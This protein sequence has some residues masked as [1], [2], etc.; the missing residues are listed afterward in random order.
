MQIF[1]LAIL[2]K[3]GSSSTMLT[4]QQ[5]LS[6]FSFFKKSTVAQF[7]TFFSTT[8]AERT[9]PGN[10]ATV[11]E[12]EKKCH[13][14][15]DT[16]GLAAVAIC[17]N[18]YPDRVA[19]TLLAKI[20]DEF[21]EMYPSGKWTGAES[22]TPFPALKGMLAKYQDPTEADALAKI[23]KELDE[24]KVILHKNMEDLLDRGEKLDDLVNKS[25]GLSASA[26]GFYKQ[27]KK[28]NSCCSV[29]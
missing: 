20:L 11:T 10:R 24:T 14:Y 18:E 22:D 9:S 23:H 19:F 7:L 6:S 16:G 8:L 25:E 1:S 28:T 5:D 3:D 27:A 17:D 4:I 15:A 21:S 13:V 26:K 29:M 12:D 2:K